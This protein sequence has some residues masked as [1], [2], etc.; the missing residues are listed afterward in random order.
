MIASSGMPC[1][2]ITCTNVPL[3]L[4]ERGGERLL[5][6]EVEHRLLH[7]GQ[8][9]RALAQAADRLGH[10]ERAR[11]GPAGDV[12]VDADGGDE[13]D[14]LLVAAADLG[15]EHARRDHPDVAGRVEAVERERVPARHDGEPVVG[16]GDRQR[17]DHVV[18]DQDADDVGVAR[19]LERG[20]GEPVGRGLLPGGVGPDADHHLAARV[21]QVQGPRAALVAVADDRDRAAG[22]LAR[23][24]RRR[25]GGSSQ[26]CSLN[27]APAGGFPPAFVSQP[28]ARM[29]R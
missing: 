13:P 19:V 7:R 25:R 24:R 16:P 28:R 27:V 17:R 6:R 14:A 8:L 26:P 29:G 12:A 23:G 11:L 1:S 9:D 22:E 3:H 10:G 5:H 18:G 4:G 20:R 15:P 2:S 21:A